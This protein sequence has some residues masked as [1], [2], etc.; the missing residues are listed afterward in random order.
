VD[1]VH[2]RGTGEGRPEFGECGHVGSMRSG[3]SD[4][5]DAER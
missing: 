1:G 3:A 4:R 2:G 5:V